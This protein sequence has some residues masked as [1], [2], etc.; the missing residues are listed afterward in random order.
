[1]MLCSFQVLPVELEQRG[2]QV[3]LDNQDRAGFPVHLEVL[4]KQVRRAQLGQLDLLVLQV[5]GCTVIFEKLRCLFVNFFGALLTLRKFVCSVGTPGQTGIQGVVGATGV[6][7]PAGSTGPIGS[8]GAAGSA[9]PVGSTGSV[10]ASGSP[11]L[12][13]ST[14]ATGEFPTTT[15]KGIRCISIKKV[16]LNGYTMLFS[17]SFMKIYPIKV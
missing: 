14:G 15:G 2:E 11:G 9:G 12:P 4:G 6:P 17:F 10:G 1:M 13:G 5:S 7:G 3:F 16:D 8:T